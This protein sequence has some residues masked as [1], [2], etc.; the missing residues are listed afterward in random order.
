MIDHDG[1]RQVLA[2]LA[3]QGSDLS[4]PAHTIHYLYFKTLEAAGAAAQELRTAGYQIR[5]VDKAPPKSLWNRIFG[6]RQF[7][8]IVETQAVPSESAVFATTDQMN[9]LAARF[10]G[11]YDG[12]EASIER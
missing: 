5:R 12:W 11:Q 2:V 7:S 3:A 9:A 10:G 4:K 1:D 8:C 6:P